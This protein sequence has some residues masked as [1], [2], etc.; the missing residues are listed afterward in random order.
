MSLKFID[1]SFLASSFEYFSDFL[2]LLLQCGVVEYFNDFILFAS[3]IFI[4]LN[5]H[6]WL[7]GLYVFFLWILFVLAKIYFMEKCKEHTK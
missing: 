7:S 6:I 2:L 3:L 4:L 1:K 5:I